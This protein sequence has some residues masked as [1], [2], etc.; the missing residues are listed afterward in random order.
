M[1][2]RVEHDRGLLRFLTC[3]SVD[4]G[5]STLIGRLLFDTGHVF[6]DQ[7]AALERDS[8]RYGTTGNDLDL[9]LLV[10]GLE[11]E[12]E[13]GITIDISHRY[14]S[15]PLRAFIIA[16]TPGHEQYTRNMAT[17]ASQADA[18]I[19]LVDAR[20]GILTQT[21]RHAT[22]CALMGIQHI[23]LAINKVDLVD[24][25]EVIFEKLKADFNRFAISIGLAQAIPVP[26]SARYGDNVVEPSAAM[27]WYRGP[28][29]LEILEM[30]EIAEEGS[31]KPLRFSVQYV[32][33]PHLDFRGFA[34]TVLS[35]TIQCG[36]TIVTAPS[37]E[38]VQVRALHGAD[39]PIAAASAGDAIVI[40]L[41]GEYDLS[42]GQMLSASQNRPE[43]ADQFSAHLVWMSAQTL[44]PG[45]GYLLRI[46]DHWAPASVTRIKHKIDV[47]TQAHVAAN[48]I[49]LNDIAEVNIATQ[50]PV[51]FDRY[52]D[53]RMT[54]S[55]ILVDRVTHE[56]AAAG[57]ILHGLR[58][59]TNVH[60]HH[61]SIDREARALM[62]GQL[63]R[64]IW[65]TG[66]SGSGKST[67][68]DALEKRLVALGKHTMLLDGDNMRHGLNRDLGFTDMD[69]VENI[70]RVG[71][72]ARLMTDAG[73]I[74]IASFISP[75]KAERA[76]VRSLL[77]ESEYFEI[78]VDV[79]LEECIK[80]DPKGLYVKAAR[81]DIP[82]FTGINSPYEAPDNPDLTIDGLTMSV[83][84]AVDVILTRLGLS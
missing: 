44:L 51:A 80:R 5:K 46:G 77:P 84:E 81:G 83:E 48:E 53:N 50:G 14:F 20:K 76:L 3:G 55:F 17:A 26:I 31:T 56:T 1:D 21:R 7:V 15:T 69:R 8:Q 19:L 37:G 2:A 60:L 58:R 36:E 13:Q 41:E 47:N 75:F 49:G 4:D 42:R 38:P 28:T 23:V 40:E 57:M 6:T 12:R 43:I 72:V 30:I 78:F 11:A 65:L 45:R 22:L 68:A 16:D 82:N 79:P 66:L 27:D 10:D 71:E 25:S 61:H 33:R 24:Y 74:V 59:A 70:R 34:G 64:C 63:P 18:A 62:K 9:A 67:I 39:G 29:L 54:G 73:L 35:G 32:I 52:R